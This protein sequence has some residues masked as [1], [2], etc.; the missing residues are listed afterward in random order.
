MDSIQPEDVEKMVKRELRTVIQRTRVI[1]GIFGVV[2]FICS[3]ILLLR[4]CAWGWFVLA[5]SV[6]VTLYGFVRAA[7]IQKILLVYDA[8]GNFYEKERKKCTT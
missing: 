6:L 7:R 2:L 1:Y 5:A 8:V 4:L 3:T